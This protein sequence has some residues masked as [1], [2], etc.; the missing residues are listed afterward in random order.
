MSRTV[1]GGVLLAADEEL[2]V[3]ELTVGARTDL[4]NRLFSCQQMF[5]CYV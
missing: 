3:E 4:I 5:H 2:R 1:V